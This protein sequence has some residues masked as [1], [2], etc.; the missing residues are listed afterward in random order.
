MSEFRA[1]DHA[2]GL[3]LQINEL[4]EQHER[5]AVQGRN[6]V[7]RRLELEIG[8]LQAELA[9]TAEQAVLQDPRS[10]PAPELHN[11]DQLTTS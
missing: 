2:M 11:A 1:A 5:A 10:E 8:D 3:E 6:E 9:A 4:I 7:A